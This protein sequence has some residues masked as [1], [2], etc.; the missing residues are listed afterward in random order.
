MKHLSGLCTSAL[1]VIALMGGGVSIINAQFEEYQSGW[2][3]GQDVSPTFDGWERN[4]DGSYSFYFGYLNRNAAEKLDIEIGPDNSIDGGPDRGQPT[5]FYPGR[6]WWVVKVVVPKDWPKE[7]RV[8]WTLRSRG[9]TNQ[10]KAWLQPEWEVNA[11]LISRNARDPFLFLR[12]DDRE[13]EDENRPPA[14]SG[15]GTQT[16]TLPQTATVV[17]TAVDDGRPKSTVP[18]EQAKGRRQPGIRFRWIVY[19]GVEPV[20]FEPETN[21]PFLAGTAKGETVVRFSAP[22][23][24]R[25]RAI[26]SDGMAFST[27]DVDVT[28]KPG[29]PGQAAR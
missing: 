29:P 25:L 11:D 7:Q 16:V 19:R 22:G 26:A 24:Y 8:V 18:A 20:R 9:R 6:Q 12:A 21:G 15:N 3:R 5:H 17:V 28:V 14:I 1:C 27:F 13:T 2:D 4:A 23:Q 10:A